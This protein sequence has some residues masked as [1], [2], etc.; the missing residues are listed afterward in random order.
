MG[1]SMSQHF[2]LNTSERFLER[3]SGQRHSYAPQI[4][5][6]NHD[7]SGKR[8]RREPSQSNRR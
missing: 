8:R 5:R 2:S 6:P 1:L 4:P 7:A 3:R